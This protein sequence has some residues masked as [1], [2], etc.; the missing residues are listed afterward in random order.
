M[1]MMHTKKLTVSLR[2]LLFFKF[3]GTYACGSRDPSI[4]QYI[5]MVEF[6][7]VIWENI[8]LIF[9]II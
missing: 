2:Y 3:K 9:G 5:N 8:Y 1:N 6:M 7:L 4:L